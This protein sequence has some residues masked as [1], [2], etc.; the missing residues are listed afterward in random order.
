MEFNTLQFLAFF[1]LFFVLYHFAARTR[2]QRLWLLVAGSLAFCGARNVRFVPVLIATG[3]ANYFMALGLARQEDETRRKNRLAA[4]VAANLAWL[5]FFKNENFFLGNA[6][7]GLLLPLGI[8][9]YTLQC[10][11]YLADVRRRAI[12]PSRSLRDFLAA[13][14][15][16]PRLAAG[17]FVRW[18]DWLPQFDEL[19]PPDWRQ[20]ERAFLLISFGLAKKTVADLV[21]PIADALFRSPGPHSA[22]ESWTGALAFAGQLYGDF[23]GYTD[24]AIGCSLLLGFSV[25]PN[26]DL[27][28]LAISPMQFWRRWHMSFTQWLYEYA[29]LPLA[30]AY[31]KRPAFSLMATVLL[32][33]LWHGSKWTFVFYGAYHG[34]LLAATQ[35]TYRRLPERWASG[36]AWL[37]RAIMTA[38]T[39]YFVVLGFTMFRAETVSQG[40]GLWRSMHGAGL[41]SAPASDAGA[42]LAAAAAALV[43]CHA[44]D[45]AARKAEVGEKPFVLWPATVVAFAFSFALDGLGKTFIYGGF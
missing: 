26:F 43:C 39:F 45:F 44:L 5:V 1:L 28:F 13:L 38:A 22:L 35:W 37:P 4:G 40:L 6:P 32:V 27:P 19:K 11:A 10:I 12:E 33:G 16:F 14:A 42:M 41:P 34:I 7:Q 23:A 17:P 20:V 15:F 9:F 25:P 31:R 36:R 18:A 21:S 2:G 29:Y 24:I 30:L 3:T 8:S